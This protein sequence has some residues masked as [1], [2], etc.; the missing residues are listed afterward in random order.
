MEKIV[1]LYKK[2]TIKTRYYANIY[3]ISLNSVI[4]SG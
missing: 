3:T 1:E 4:K 2:D